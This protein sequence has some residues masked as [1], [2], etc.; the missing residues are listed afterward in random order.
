MNTYLKNPWKHYI[1]YIEGYS[2]KYNPERSK[3]MDRGTVFHRVMELVAQGKTLNEAQSL[4]VAEGHAKGF[5]QEAKTLGVLASERYF[6]ENKVVPEELH[7]EIIH[8]EYKLEYD[9]P[10][11]NT[12]FIGFIDAIRKNPDGTVTLIDYKTYSTKPNEEQHKNALQAHMYMYVADKLGFNVRDFIFDCINP[13]EKIVGR[14]YKT[15]KITIPFNEVSSY[16]FK[17]FCEIVSMI[18]QY[19]DFKLYVPGDYMPDGYDYLFKVF[20]GEINEDWETFVEKNFE[21]NSRNGD[22]ADGV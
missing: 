2:E 9:L 17:E 12:K 15:H 22:Y 21:A 8:T 3:Y 19:P 6:K 4:A 11:E 10:I 20:T 13:K 1:K 16:Y 5:T 14:N 7:N 18:K